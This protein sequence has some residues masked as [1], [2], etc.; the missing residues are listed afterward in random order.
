MAGI[1]S[2][3]KLTEAGLTDF[4]VYEKA[5]ACRRHV[6]GEHVSRASRATCRR[7]STPT[8]SRRPPTGATASRP[9]TEI[10]AYFERVAARARRRARD[11]RF[12]DE[13]DELHVRRRTLAA[14]DRSRAPRRGRRRDR[15]DRRAAPSRATPTSTGSTSFAGA[16]FHSSR[17]DHDVPLDG[18]RVGVIGTGS[19]AVQIVVGARRPG[20]AALAVPAHRAVDHAAGEPGV[21]R[22]GEGARSA[23]TPSGWRTLHDEP[24][25]RCSASFANAVV[26]ADSPEIA[27]DRAARASR[28]SRTTS[29]IPSCASGCGPTTA[30]RASG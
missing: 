30:P 2:A 19:T 16:V 22:R 23:P 9:A 12:G 11:V 3:I 15:G 7:T 20:R 5:D 4:T 17:W 13:V 8:R 6:A 1:L 14:R 25:A 24:R 26:D 29:T 28:T 10:Q 18:A 21:H 27:D